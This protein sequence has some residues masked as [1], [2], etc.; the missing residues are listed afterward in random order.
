MQSAWFKT[1]PAVISAVMVIALLMQ[2]ASVDKTSWDARPYHLQVQQAVNDVPYVVGDWI[3]QD[4]PVPTSAV[5]MLRA[6]VVLSRRYRNVSTGSQV[7][8]VLVQCSDARDLL[9]HYPPVCYPSHGWTTE[10]TTDRQ[11]VV[12]TETIS[13]VEYHFSREE[14][15]R[16][17]PLVVQNFM[18]LPGGGTSRGM[19]AVNQLAQD[20]QRK[21][22]GAAQ[23]QLVCSG[24]MSANERDRAF[25]TLVA[26]AFPATSVIQFAVPEPLRIHTDPSSAELAAAG[27]QQESLSLSSYQD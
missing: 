15:Q 13:G 3:G 10:S 14:L 5:Q 4:V 7:V 20:Q 8:L 2:K 26:A 27:A 1:L 21:F 16:V 12:G 23:V 18:V 17:E 25:E 11:W 9:G 19:A 24:D 6:N 22:Y